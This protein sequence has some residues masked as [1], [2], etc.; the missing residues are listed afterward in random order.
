MRQTFTFIEISNNDY[1]YPSEYR[2]VI[3]RGEISPVGD[4]RPVC[5]TRHLS[6]FIKA[7]GFEII[8]MYQYDALDFTDAVQWLAGFCFISRNPN[9][10]FWELHG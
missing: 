1:E 4:T 7:R 8:G 3:V 2:T 9:T 5:R 6:R 10:P